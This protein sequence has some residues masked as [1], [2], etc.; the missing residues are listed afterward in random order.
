M[1]KGWD[2]IQQQAAA[3]AANRERFQQQKLPKL[4]VGEKSPGPFQIRICEQGPDVNNYPVHEYKVP[5][6]RGGFW[7]RRF[8]CL[9]EVQQPCPGCNAGLKQKRRGVL[10]VIQRNRP[11]HRKD[12]DGKDIQQPDGTFIVDGWQDEVVIVDVGGPTSEMLRKADADYRGLMCRDFVVQFSGDTFQSWTLTPA[13]DAAG[14][15]SPTS[16]SENDQVLLARKH[17]LDLYMKPPTYEEA[18]KIIV[19]YGNNSG[20]SPNANA[21]APPVPPQGNAMAT[22]GA[23]FMAGAAV[24][25]GVALPVPQT[26]FG[27]AQAQPVPAAVPPTPPPPAAAP[28]YDPAPVAAPVQQTAPPAAPMP[29]PAPPAP[30]VPPQAP[31]APVAAPQ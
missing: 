10:N 19:Q 29:A 12:K 4:V 25:P 27:A 14:N 22:P 16:M 9:S 31:P 6:G 24:P 17:D 30:P 15:S 3:T 8:T 23:G 21:G 28:V 18:A 11:I 26:A 20:A 1:A 7:N 2:G 5:D 13:M